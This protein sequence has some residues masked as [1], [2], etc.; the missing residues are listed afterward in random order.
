MA[1]QNCYI[2]IIVPV[3][4]V[5][6][7]LRKC[8]DSIIQ[9]S[10]T[11]WE[12]LLVDDGSTDTSSQICDEYSEKDSRIRTIHVSNGG[13][14]KARNIALDNAKGEWIMFVDADDWLH[15][16]CLMTCTEEVF[17]NDLDMLQFSAV[18][19]D[20]H[21]NVLYRLE[22]GTNIC[23]FPEYVSQEK[24]NLTVW[25][26][27]LKLSIIQDNGLRFNTNL[28]LAEDQVFM[29]SYMKL[30][31]RLK[32]IPDVMYYYLYVSGRY[33][34]KI[35]TDNVFKSIEFLSEYKKQVNEFS[36]DFDRAIVDFFIKLLAYT[37][38]PITKLADKYRRTCN[39]PT[40]RLRTH[41]LF[42]SGCNINIRL[43]MI[44]Y[45]LLLKMRERI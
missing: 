40:V 39:K 31:H 29:T 1:Q 11:D 16:D 21:K 4:N 8:V 23:S 34:C 36:D 27:L 37:D 24:Y 41:R 22:K 38:Y 7:Y 10:Y 43:T 5:E 19:V 13:V 15:P 42:V 3:F 9:Q 33:T 35:N 28:S 17:T 14:S 6:K 2:S 25:G 32:S 18:R 44:A 30:C 20:E 45:R 26:G 12:L